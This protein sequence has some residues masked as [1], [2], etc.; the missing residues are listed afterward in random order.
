MKFYNDKFAFIRKKN[1]CTVSEFCRAAD[2]SRTTLWQWE[3]GKRVPAEE[4]VY[5]LALILKIEVNEISDLPQRYPSAK[6]NPGP[7]VSSFREIAATGKEEQQQF[8]G[9]L[10]R[11]VANIEK[12]LEQAN[13]VIRAL[14]ESFDAMFYVKDLDLKYVLANKA[15]L[16]NVALHYSYNVLG[17]D[18]GIFFNRK[19]AAENTAQDKKVILTGKGIKNIEKYIPGSRKHKMGLISKLPIFARD[20]AIIGM[21]GAS[22]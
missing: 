18:D 2:I 20:G 16:N 7:L 13:I 17:K 3:S 14:I 21:M 9:K 4:T 1:R 6:T 10:S 11:E 8:I 22:Y 19:E 12:K 5:F 15:F